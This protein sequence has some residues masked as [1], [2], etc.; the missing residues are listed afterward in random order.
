M[1]TIDLFQ[2]GWDPKK[3]T[4]QHDVR[5]ISL[6]S[7]Y[8]VEPHYVEGIRFH[9]RARGYVFPLT[10]NGEAVLDQVVGF[11]DKIL[12]ERLHLDLS[13]TLDKVVM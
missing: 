9:A 4:L 6:I 11:N 2:R 10:F 13:L 5:D 3:A 7:S 12:P 1:A 8:V